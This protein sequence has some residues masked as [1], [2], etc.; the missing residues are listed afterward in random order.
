[1]PFRFFQF[2]SLQVVEN[3]IKKN[4]IAYQPV[5]EMA[6]LASG[7]GAVAHVRTDKHPQA[8]LY[9]YDFLYSN[10]YLFQQFLGFPT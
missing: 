9:S 7:S 10:D 1:M 5:A 3:K 4:M 8:C 2:A 6:T